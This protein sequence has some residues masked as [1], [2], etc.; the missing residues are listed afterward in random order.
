MA[1]KLTPAPTPAKCANTEDWKDQY[2]TCATYEK[3]G[4]CYKGKAGKGWKSSWGKLPAAVTKACCVC[5][6][7]PTLVKK[8]LKP[9]AT[10]YMKSNGKVQISQQKSC[11]S[12]YTCRSNQGMY[13]P[14]MQSSSCQGTNDALIPMAPPHGRIEVPQKVFGRRLQKQSCGGFAGLRCPTGMLCNMGNQGG[15]ADGMG[16]CVGKISAA[17]FIS[18]SARSCVF[19]NPSA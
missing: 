13:N 8:I 3:S 12:G 11:P 18:K 17:S 6:K 5:G 1:P 7:A 14:N 19:L 2:G 9:G 4:W 10:C 16:V 15:M